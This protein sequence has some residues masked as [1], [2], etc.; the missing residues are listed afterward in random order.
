MAT[1]K[2]PPHKLVVDCYQNT[3]GTLIVT[4]LGS[5]GMTSQTIKEFQNSQFQN[6]PISSN[7]H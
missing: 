7:M 3:G 6:S 5:T 2:A 1:T 4:E